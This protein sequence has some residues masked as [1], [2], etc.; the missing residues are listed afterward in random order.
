MSGQLKYHFEL[1]YYE[2]WRDRIFT[3]YFYLFSHNFSYTFEILITYFFNINNNYYKG[4]KNKTKLKIY[5][6]S[7]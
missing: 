6:L 1:F 3:F 5:H 7:L 2:R 4:Y